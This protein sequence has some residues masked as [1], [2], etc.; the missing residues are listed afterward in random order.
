MVDLCLS[1]TMRPRVLVAHRATDALTSFLASIHATTFSS[2]SN[3]WTSTHTDPPRLPLDPRSTHA[4]HPLVLDVEE[5]AQCHR[6]P[7]HALPNSRY[8]HPDQPPN[9]HHHYRILP[10]SF[11][12]Q[13][14][15]SPSLSTNDSAGLRRGMKYS[16]GRTT[17]PIPH[18][19][20]L[21][22]PGH[23]PLISLSPP[24]FPGR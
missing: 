12:E 8:A 18:D 16:S 2:D 17:R 19:S 23:R 11:P 3:T 4:S 10:S 15:E 6:K 1:P 13:T 22:P 20:T 24:R 14:H 9:P 7:E 21:T 5:A